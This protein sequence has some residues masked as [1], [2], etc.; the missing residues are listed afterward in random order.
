MSYEYKYNG[1]RHSTGQSSLA[2][3]GVN[4]EKLRQ[5]KRDKLQKKYRNI[6]I[7]L[8][9][10]IV[11]SIMLIIMNHHR[12]SP[13][14]EIVVTADNWSDYFVISKEIIDTSIVLDGG[15][16]YS[17]Q[18]NYSIRLNDYY[19]KYVDSS[20]TSTVT[21]S[22][23]YKECMGLFEMDYK[24]LRYTEPDHFSTVESCNAKVV[25]EY[26]NSADSQTNIIYS[27]TIMGGE[28][29]AD[30]VGFGLIGTEFTVTSVSGTLYLKAG[31]E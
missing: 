7:A 17:M 24:N 29:P 30:P 9:A 25:V 8:V 5:A 4:E 2:G 12:K 10:V 27:G 15:A 1:N 22:L 18:T 13:P 26:P 21:F 31:A 19:A 14:K 28:D 3:S 16:L 11:L 20:Q 23:T 6:S